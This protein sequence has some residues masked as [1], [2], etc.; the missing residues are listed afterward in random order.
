MNGSAYGCLLGTITVLLA[1]ASPARAQRYE[2]TGFQ[3][4]AHVGFNSSTSD[5]QTVD[6]VTGAAEG[7]GSSSSSSRANG[8]VQAGYDK[9][10]PSRL[11]VGGQVGVS[12]FGPDNVTTFTN[13]RNTQT[14]E[15]NN[16]LSGAVLGRVG[17]AADR[18][19][20]YG[21]TGLSWASTTLTRTQ[22]AGTVGTAGPGTVETID[23]TR[24]GFAVGG[25]LEY[26][27]ASRV[28]V[29]AEYRH[30]HTGDNTITFPLAQRATTSTSNTNGLQLSVNYR[31]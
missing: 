9:M 30:G 10:T 29:G 31:F 1:F 28:R 13:G 22:V 8:G 17:Y 23:S 27:I 4:G 14:N 18:A 5:S 6:T 2:W 20:I 7:P 19:L 12:F 15:S 25:G 24:S 21:T 26:A 3:A 11:L 16:K